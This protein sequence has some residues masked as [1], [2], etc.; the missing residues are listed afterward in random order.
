MSIDLSWSSSAISMDYIKEQFNNIRYLYRGTVQQ[1]PW[2]CSTISVIYI[3]E[4]LSN[5][6][7]F[8]QGAAQQ[9]PWFLSMDF[10]R[11]TCTYFCKS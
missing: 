3:K 2:N 9:Y 11:L 4:Q 6:H 7:G 5:I 1:Y 8:Y 10:I